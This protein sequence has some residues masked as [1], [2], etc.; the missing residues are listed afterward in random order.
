MNLGAA[1][2]LDAILD[3]YYPRDLETGER[4]IPAFRNRRPINFAALRKATNG[5]PFIYPVGEGNQ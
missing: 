1:N 2:A 5:R 3:L 4:Y